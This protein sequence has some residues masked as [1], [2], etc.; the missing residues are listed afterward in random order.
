MCRAPWRAARKSTKV[1]TID[2]D[3]AILTYMREV[4]NISREF[5][6]AMDENDPIPIVLNGF[7]PHGGV[8]HIRMNM[9]NWRSLVV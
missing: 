2:P 1:Y 5:V 8:L 9:D 3:E 6:D 7:M 4:E